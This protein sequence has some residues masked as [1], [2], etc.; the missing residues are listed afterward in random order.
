MVA[1]GTYRPG[2]GDLQARRKRGGQGGWERVQGPKTWR[3]EGGLSPRESASPH[4]KGEGR[5]GQACPLPKELGL[6][7]LTGSDLPS[8]HLRPQCGGALWA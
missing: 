6:R 2:E 4:E 5:W 8:L 7:D 3:R 1:G